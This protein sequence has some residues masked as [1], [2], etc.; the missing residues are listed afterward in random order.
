MALSL[1]IIDR[2][3]IGNKRL[4][5]VDVT[6]DSSYASGGESFT[7][8]DLGIDSIQQVLFGDAGRGY[9]PKFDYTNNTMKLFGPAPP[10]CVEEKH[11]AATA[12]VTL[13]YPAAFILA[14]V[15]AGDG[16]MW[17]ATGTATGDLAANEFCLTTA[18]TDGV[19]STITTKGASDVI[20]VTY[21]TQAWKEVYDNLVQEESVAL[22]TGATDLA[23][24]ILL[25]GMCSGSTAGHLIPVD[26]SDTTAAGEVGILFNNATGA[27]D[28]NA[29]ENGETGKVTY[30]KRP[31]SGFLN[32]RAV[33]NEDATSSGG[34]PYLQALDLPCLAWGLSGYATVSGQTSKKFVTM[35][36]TAAA[37][38][39]NTNWY[40]GYITGT[41]AALTAAFTIG[42]KDNQTLTSA[43]YVHGVGPWEIP[44]LE[45]LEIKNA[46]DVSD[47]VIRC[48]IIG[49]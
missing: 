29:N 17:E 41:G 35:D 13:D 40:E 18:I 36:E 46:S 45:P 42:F 43:S 19:R 1:S 9:S 28:I 48:S 44:G 32:D 3:V 34:D 47:V 49:F 11:T 23:N 22:A 2:T 38:E 39:C 14:V 15:K 26:T 33:V 21:I 20:F 8:T 4:V 12:A 24:K 6:F 7:A 31:A 16:Q 5:I 30:I 37:G 27:L 25:F 10:I